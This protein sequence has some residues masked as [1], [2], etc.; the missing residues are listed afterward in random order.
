MMLLATASVHNL[1]FTQELR[2]RYIVMSLTFADRRVLAS[3]TSFVDFAQ[4]N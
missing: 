3:Q 1:L 4:Q 2:D